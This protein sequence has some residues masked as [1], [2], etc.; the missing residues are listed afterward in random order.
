DGLT[1]LPN[2]ALFMDRLERSLVSTSRR[3]CTVAVVFVDLDGFKAINDGYGHTVGDALLREVG[4]RLAATLRPEDTLARLGGDEFCA[5]CLDLSG[6]ED[7]LSI[8]RRLE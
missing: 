2:R 3:R 5:L 4:E 6:P 8:V 1:G 7:V